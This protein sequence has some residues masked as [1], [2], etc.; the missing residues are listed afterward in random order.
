MNVAASLAEVLPLQVVGDGA[1]EWPGIC[2]RPEAVVHPASPTEV[3][4]TMRW[5]A[6]H[7]IGVAV[8]ASGRRFHGVRAAERPFLVMCTDRLTGT[9]IYEPA[10]LTLTAKSGTRL[11]TLAEELGAQ[12]QWLPYDPPHVDERTLG[13]LVAT[14]ESGPLWMGYGELRNHVLGLT[15]V[16]G[17]GRVL[18]L[19]GRVVKNV[20]GFDLLKAVVG[21]RGRLG[22][23]TSVC[24]RA[25]PRPSVDRVL[26]LRGD[27]VAALVAVGRQ[28][29]TAPTMPVSSVLVAPARAPS[30]GAAL[31]VRLHGAEPTVDADQ[32]TLERH[33]GVSFERAT[34]AV[35]LLA[36]A[37]DHVADAE[38]ELTLSVLPSRLGDALVAVRDVLGD[39]PFAAD[40]YKGFARVAAG[41]SD[42]EAASRLRARIEALGGALTARAADR[43]RDV[44]SL[45]SRL[46]AAAAALTERLEA[47]FD[48]KGVLWPCRP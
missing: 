12:K 30:A 27:S 31:L 11:A 9:E 40:T 17:D 6:A 47:V 10:D 25:F 19:G 26:V 41:E 36:S 23:I 14:G 32:K 43:G 16:C 13:G 24:V 38:V 45:G 15:V 46:P 44:A 8:V 1:R 28:V 34:D 33:C 7:S 20:A 4:D 21:A 39:V 29:G 18:K 5:A 48:P 35:G 2:G 42:F 37:R 22:V 3:A